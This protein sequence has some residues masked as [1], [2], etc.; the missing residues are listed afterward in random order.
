MKLFKIICIISIYLGFTLAIDTLPLSGDLTLTS[1]DD[2]IS[3]LFDSS[4]FHPTSSLNKEIYFKVKVTPSY[5]ISD[6]NVKY[7]FISLSTDIPASDGELQSKA[8][9]KTET[10]DS[11]SNTIIY[12]SITKISDTNNYLY[13]KLLIQSESTVVITNTVKDTSTTSN[14][15]TGYTDNDILQKYSSKTIGASKDYIIFDSGDFDDG[16]EIHFKIKALY[17]EFIYDFIEYYYM[18][19]DGTYNENY[20]RVYFTGVTETDYINGVRYRTSYFNIKKKSSEFE[21]TDGKYLVSY[22]FAFVL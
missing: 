9:T 18:S 3:F 13:I 16:E 5:T 6:N 14:I 10:T 19:S 2:K 20:R 17:Y 22:C 7:A 4:S 15:P 8:Y 11:N 21:G 1:E 12:F